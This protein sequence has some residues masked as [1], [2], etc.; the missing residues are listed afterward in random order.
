MNLSFPADLHKIHEVSS[1]HR[2]AQIALHWQRQ[3]SDIGGFI[4]GEKES[5]PL[6]LPKSR[7][8][9]RLETLLPSTS[10]HHFF[11]CALSALRREVAGHPPWRSFVPPGATAHTRILFGTFERK[12]AV[13]AFTPPLAAA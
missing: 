5:M 11:S 13:S 3:T 9:M 7:R 4:R 8:F 10:R 12:D 2:S 6:A 1:A